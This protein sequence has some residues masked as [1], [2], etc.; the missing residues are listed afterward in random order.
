M[1]TN[2]FYFGVLCS[3]YV[4]KQENANY[5]SIYEQSASMP[6]KGTHKG[7]RR[8][9]TK[10]DR[11]KELLFKDRDGQSYAVVTVMLGNGRLQA[12]CEDSQVRL[13]KIRGS[14]RRSEWISVGDVILV[15]LREF[16]DEK[17]DVLHRYMHEDVRR[18][19]RLGELGM[20]RLDEDVVVEATFD[21]GEDLVVFDDDQDAD[22]YIDA[23]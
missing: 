6:R 2:I 16:Q 15:A 18:L 17:A 5:V 20:L 19:R 23:L 14:M 12:R 9:S 8:A 10:A 13:C 1:H 7:A 4:F 22:A 11:G 3:K 21:E